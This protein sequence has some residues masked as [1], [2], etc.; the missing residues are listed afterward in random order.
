MSYSDHSTILCN[1]SSLEG[2]SGPLPCLYSNNSIKNDSKIALDPLLSLDF[3]GFEGNNKLSTQHKKSASILA[4]SVQEIA[5]T[6]GIDKLGFLTLTFKEFITC[7]KEATRRLNSLN[8][9]I[10]KDR[11]LAHIRVFE[12]CKSG[13]IHFH[14]L[15]VLRSDIRTGFDFDAI[16][17]H[18]YRSA[19]D[20]LRSEWSFWRKTAKKYGF[21]RTELL[22]VRTTSEGIA[23]YVGKYIS[24]NIE[25]RI[26]EDKGVRLV[27]YSKNARS[28]STR[29]SFV[30]E[31]SKEWRGKVKNFAVFVAKKHG[32]PFPCKYED[33]KEYEGKNWAYKWRDLILM[34]PSD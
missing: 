1:S 3:G 23:R 32:L 8:T 2:S 9:N 17:N 4:H 20:Y 24:K 6:Y 16:K 28:G 31:G 12:R 29:F 18:D 11:Y 14:L 30:S 34:L 5:K 15:V 13:R 22:P 19:N 7:A 26:P 21:G 27:S 10:L 33:L 25:S